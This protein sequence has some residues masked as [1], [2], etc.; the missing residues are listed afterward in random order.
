MGKKD[1]E[2]YLKNSEFEDKYAL[3]LAKIVESNQPEGIIIVPINFIVA[4]NSNSIRKLFFEKYQI[5]KLKYFTTQVFDD[6]SYNVIAFYFKQSKINNKKITIQVF[7]EN[8]IRTMELNDDYNLKN[9]T[10]EKI[11]N[12]KNIINCRRI[13]ETDLVSGNNIIKCAY[14]DFSTPKEYRVDNKTKTILEKNILLLN[15]IDKKEEK[16]SIEDISNYKVKS[17][18]GKITSRNMAS[19]S[20]DIDVDTQKKL[21]PL[22]ND[23][24]NKLREETFSM[25]LT[26]FRDG[27]RKRISFDFFY[28]IICYCYEQYILKKQ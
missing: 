21:I 27:N 28:R 10:I 12:Q 19:V 24:L 6:T 7:P 23:L 2:L 17:L 3:A 18:I 5:I 25:F 8:I 20:V 9:E 11:K 4:E 13:I 14:N 26:N 15:C 22:V 1:K 16:I